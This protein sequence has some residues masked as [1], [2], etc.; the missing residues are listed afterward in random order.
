[1]KKQNSF[2]AHG[3]NNLVNRIV[4]EVE[5][6]P[7]IEKA[8][9]LKIYQISEADISV[10]Y[11]L[12]D[13]ALSPLEGPM[14]EKEFYSVLDKEYIERSGK[15]YAWTIPLAFPAAKKEAKNFKI[16]QS[17]AVKNVFGVIMGILEI[18]SIY[19]FDKARYNQSVYG[20][21]RTDHPGPR[22]FNDDSRDYLLGGKIWALP[23]LNHPVYGKYMLTP[24]ESRI[25]FGER[26]WER[27]AA[28][29]TRNALHRAHEY[30][31]VYGMEKLT[32]EGFFTGIV[33]NP[34]VGAT[35]SDDAPAD[36][37]M[38]TYEALIK[39]SL[40]GHGDKD[41]K[42]WK[43]K[44]YDLAD[45]LILIGLDMK[46]FY[47]GPKEAIMH[48][49]YRQNYGFTDIIIG[50]KHADAHFDDD[51]PVWG[52]FDA[53]EKFE[54][55]KGELKIK[56]LKVDF[57]AY[58]EELGRVG[59][60]NK[61]K[62][63][64]Y[65]IISISGK[66]LRA[67]LES[68]QEVDERIM[69]KPVAGILSEYYAQAKQTRQIKSTNIT[70]HETGISKQDREKRNNHKGAIIWLTGLPCS[71]KSTIAV[72]LQALLF[73]MGAD[74]YILDG[75]NIR[76]GL[77]SNL[78]FSPQDRE[79]NIRRI[80]EVAKLFADA[81]FLVIA[82]FISP[83][84]KDRDRS[85]S[86]VAKG[87]FIEVFINTD[88]AVCEERDTKGLY[89]KARRGEIKEFTGIS[90]P[91]EK[92]QNPEITID[93]AKSSKEDCARQILGYLLKNGYLRNRYTS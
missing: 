44:D 55:L 16:G 3:G 61:Y 75:D 87:D 48:A 58:F 90:A 59:L 52:D 24:Q 31:L 79:E 33:L 26:R 73:E 82:S 88:L 37:R 6:Q 39:S 92:P 50:R 13:G 74:T 54:N 9:Q 70:W 65:K 71:G 35:K 57:A 23:Q 18:S 93:T 28:F 51:Q 91:Y 22:I 63:K 80:G 68:N 14:E 86:I 7:L 1:M 8:L 47:A 89:K 38:K 83:Y 72:E 20:T 15:K 62:D 76:H 64:G 11:R 19:P 42:F 32:K 2:P 81:G 84:R 56:P 60:V 29:Q 21:K 36:V 25:L 4:P 77:N 27:I 10:F 66:E 67:K 5:R 53:Q 34:L 40:L 41:D 12:A 45:Q 78:G 69:R 43:S 46:M 17:L 49:I 85:R 30:A